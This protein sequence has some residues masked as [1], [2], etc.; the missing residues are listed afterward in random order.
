MNLDAAM[1]KIHGLVE[2]YAAN[3]DFQKDSKLC[4]TNL[5][6]LNQ[7]DKVL[8]YRSLSKDAN[9]PV[10]WIEGYSVLDGSNNNFSAKFGDLERNGIQNAICA[11]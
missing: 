4:E 6:K 10:G 11:S 9:F 3:T 8:I 7:G 1:I 2:L 5:E